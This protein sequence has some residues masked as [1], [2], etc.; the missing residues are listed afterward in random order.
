[1]QKKHRKNHLNTLSKAGATLRS[2]GDLIKASRYLLVQLSMLFV[3]V[4]GLLRM[5]P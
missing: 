5:L 4:E 2:L 1:M 3:T